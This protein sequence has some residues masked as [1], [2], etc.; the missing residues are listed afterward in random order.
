MHHSNQIEWK[1][2]SF[3]KKKGQLKEPQTAMVQ[4]EIVCLYHEEIHLIPD[5][6][7]SL[8]NRDFEPVSVEFNK[9]RRGQVDIPAEGINRCHVKL[10][11]TA[12]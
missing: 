7:H 4:L 6:L 1:E 5:I 10:L 2:S 9:V 11:H 12:P 3:F 8:Q